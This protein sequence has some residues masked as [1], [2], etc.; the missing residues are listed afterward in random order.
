MSSKG[1]PWTPGSLGPLRPPNP[2][3]IRPTTYPN[4]SERRPGYKHSTR[5]YGR[6]VSSR[7]T[8]CSSLDRKTHDLGCN[9]SKLT[10]PL[11]GGARRSADLGFLP[12]EASKTKQHLLWTK[13]AQL[14]GVG[15]VTPREKLKLLSTSFASRSLKLH[16]VERAWSHNGEASR[17]PDLRC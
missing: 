11:G 10:T 1:N 17:P 14:L 13:N 7:P 5:R 6:S 15:G 9:N 3:Q 16:C 2:H 12:K 4:R 8:L